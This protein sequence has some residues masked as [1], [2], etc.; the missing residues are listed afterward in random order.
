[1]PLLGTCSGARGTGLILSPEGYV[2]CVVPLLRWVPA[3]ALSKDTVYALN[4]AYPMSSVCV[5]CVVCV[6]RLCIT[7]LDVSFQGLG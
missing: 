5:W 1:M 2:V 6:S 4:K 3:A 7:C